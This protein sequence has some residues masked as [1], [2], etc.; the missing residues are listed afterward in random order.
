MVSEP[1]TFVAVTWQEMERDPAVASFGPGLP[2]A[3]V[4]SALPASRV[5]VWSPRNVDGPGSS[6]V[7]GLTSRVELNVLSVTR[8]TLGVSVPVPATLTLAPPKMCTR[9]GSIVA[10][11]ATLTIGNGTP[12]FSRLGEISAPSLLDS[13][14]PPDV[15]VTLPSAPPKGALVPASAET[16]VSMDKVRARR[17]ATS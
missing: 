10:P 17:W 6:S 1:L 15:T 14:S 13:I 4:V 9:A 11:A 8:K 16:P 5:I 7:P 3:Y 12:S 2:G